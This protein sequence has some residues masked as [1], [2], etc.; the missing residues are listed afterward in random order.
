M[1]TVTAISHL[2]RWQLLTVAVRTHKPQILATIVRCVS[3]DVINDER[4]CHAIP[5]TVDPTDGAAP[6]LLRMQVIANKVALVR[7]AAAL[8]S[9]EPHLQKHA[10]TAQLLTCVA[11][12]DPSLTA[13]D[14]DSAPPHALDR[15]AL[16]LRLATDRFPIRMR[17]LIHASECQW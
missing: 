4:E 7:H 17:R 10:A 8:A 13:L 16:T 14:R 1:A 6:V 2:V 15:H 12:V 5:L 3:I 11:A 9:L